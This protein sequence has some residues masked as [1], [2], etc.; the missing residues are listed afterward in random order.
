MKRLAYIEDYITLMADTSFLWPPKTPLINLARYDE[1]IVNS[2]AEQIERGLGFTDRQ[3][4]LAHKIVIK[5]RKQWAAAGYD[6]SAQEHD[7]D[8]RLP[9]R[10]IDRSK[11]IDLVDNQIEIRFPYDQNMIAQIRAG[12]NDIPGRLAFDREHRCWIA[13]AIE[14]RMKWAHEFG[15][16]NSF[17]FGHAFVNAMT[18]IQQQPAHAISL[19]LDQ[20]GFR[21][22][23]AADSLNDLVLANGG[24]GNSNLLKLVDLSAIAGYTVSANV[25]Q[26]LEHVHAR[27]Q[28]FLY[29]RDINVEYDQSGIDLT[30]VIEYAELVDRW[31]IYVYESGS[32]VMR[33]QLNKY[34]ADEDIVDRKHNP[35]A[36]IT[37]RVIYFNH[38]RLAETAIPL[39]V[40]THTLMIGHRRQQMLQC[41][42][43]VIYY[44]QRVQEHA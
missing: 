44:S 22:S 36:V 11:H 10:Q 24:F 13:A 2:M 31:P 16:N 23:N 29:N 14:P 12:V 34:F 43:K 21:I 7:A 5:Y 35:Q 28:K 15:T 32:S 6:V 20:N 33:Q 40:T 38:W 17:E 41:A 37:G 42:D 1:P 26:K 8:F 19:E 39:L 18:E 9:I 30:P 27:T 25:Q 3:A 4:L